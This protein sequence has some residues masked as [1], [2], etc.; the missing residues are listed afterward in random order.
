MFTFSFNSS[1]VSLFPEFYGYQV[2]GSTV[3]ACSVT[4][5]VPFQ[6]CIWIYVFF[7]NSKLLPYKY[8][9][10]HFHWITK[11]MST[12]LSLTKS[13]EQCAPP[14]TLYNVDQSSIFWTQKSL[15]LEIS[16]KFIGE[17]SILN[18][19]SVSFLPC[20]IFQL[21]TDEKNAR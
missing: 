11:F 1:I 20:W 15:I 16:I 8:V 12:D 4:P 3:F 13:V 10:A 5:K 7:I 21:F 14:G 18:H 19:I 9:F 17:V 6:K 2:L